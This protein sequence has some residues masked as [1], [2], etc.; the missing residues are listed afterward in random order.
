[1]SQR[2]PSGHSGAPLH[3]SGP[4]AT[5]VKPE[6]KRPQQSGLS[7]LRRSSLD[8]TDQ[9]REAAAGP[10]TPAQGWSLPRTLGAAA[11]AGLAQTALSLPATGAAPVKSPTRRRT[12]P[13]CEPPAVTC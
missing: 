10:A 12:C 8:A 5:P 11:D 3:C 13:H 7:E 4:T 9:D 1:M 6:Q 2:M